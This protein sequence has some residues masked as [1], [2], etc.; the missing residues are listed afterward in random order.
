MSPGFARRPGG[1]RD[2][3]KERTGIRAE[4]NQL[5]ATTQQQDEIQRQVRQVADSLARAARHERR[6]GSDLS[7]EALQQAAEAIRQVADKT[8]EAAKQLAEM[9]RQKLLDTEQLTTTPEE[10]R[11]VA[12]AV[13][14]TRQAIGQQL[15]NLAGITTDRAEQTENGEQTPQGSGSQQQEMS[16]EM[17]KEMSQNK[18]R[19]L[20]DLDR[21]LSLP[22][23]SGENQQKPRAEAEEATNSQTSMSQSS[24]LAQLAAEQASAMARA[25]QAIPKEAV[26]A[27]ASMAQSSGNLSPDGRMEGQPLP[28]TSANQSEPTLVTSLQDWAELRERRS[29]DSSEGRRSAGPSKYRRQIEAYFRSISKKANQ[30]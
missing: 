25:Q 1:I 16:Q 14:E 29:E 10:G 5:G 4:Q 22:Q 7:V 30:P 19:A 12:A 3:L 21:A 15:E 28:A 18:A 13:A 24:T 2:R 26:F 11:K 8:I 23:Q 17:S 20:D 9:Q 27:A 6:L